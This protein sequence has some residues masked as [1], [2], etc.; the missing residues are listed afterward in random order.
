MGDI[1]DDRR[2]PRRQRTDELRLVVV[3]VDLA[4]QNRGN[5]IQE[6]VDLGLGGTFQVV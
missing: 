1:F 6:G 5:D 2:Q 4:V 3:A